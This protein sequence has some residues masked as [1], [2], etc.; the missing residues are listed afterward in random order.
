MNLGAILRCAFYLGVDRV[1]ATAKNW[2]V[3]SCKCVYLH[4][5]LQFV[6]TLA[7]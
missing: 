7:M 3:H 2:L 1:V 4:E 5:V 6:L